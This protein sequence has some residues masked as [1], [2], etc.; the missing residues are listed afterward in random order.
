MRNRRCF[1]V[2]L[3]VGLLFTQLLTAQA[4]D[5]RLQNKAVVRGQVLDRSTGKGILNAY[6]E[7]LNYHPTISTSTD[8]NGYFELKNIPLGHQR[9]HVV[10]EGY[11]EALYTEL[12]IAGKESVV[13]ISMEEQ[14]QM[15]IVTVEGSS[16]GERTN[17]FRNTKQATI[18]PMNAVSARPLN[19]EEV[20][21]FV[22]GFNDP[23]RALTN[24]PGLYN[25]DDSQNY[26]I[27]R[28]NS[29]QG[30]QN[31]VEGVPIENPNH[32]P[33]L[34]HTGGI[35]PLVNSNA[36]ANSDFVNGAMGAHYGNVYSGVLDI[37]LRKGNNR[38]HEFMAQIGIFGAEAMAEGPISKGK[39]SYMVV[40]RIGIFSLL[41][42]AQID[43][44]TNAAPQYYDL[45]FKINRS[46]RRGG[47][48]S[49]FGIGGYA[50]VD[51]LDKDVD[52]SDIF[53]ERGNNA[54][55]RSYNFLAGVRNLHY[56]N[57]TTSLK[58]TISGVLQH[59][60]QHQDTLIDGM[61]PTLNYDGRL[62]YDRYGVQS[63]F[64]K[65]FSS[66]LL[67]RMGLQSFI[68]VYDTYRRYDIGK[69]YFVY[70]QDNLFMGSLFGQVQY[71]FSEKLTTTVGLH[72]YVLSLN[73]RNWSVEPRLAINWNLHQKHH[74]SLGYGWHSK[75]QS[76][77]FL[78]G[79]RLLP[80]GGYE[81]N[82][83]QLGPT[84]SHHMVLTY[85]WLIAKSWA[86]KFNTYVQYN[87]DLAVERTPSSYAAMNFEASAIQRPRTDLVNGG[88]QLNYGIEASIERFL[89]KGYYGL[90]SGTFQRSFYKG[91]DG[92]VRSTAYDVP[93]MGSLLAGKSFKI[94]KQKRNSIYADVRF[95]IRS[96]APTTP[97]DLEASRL[98]QNVVFREDQAFSE[99]LGMYKRLDLRLGMR[100]NHPTRRSSHHVYI[101]V[102]NIANFRNDL[103]VAYRVKEGRTV[104]AKQFGLF[105]N[106]L[107]QIRF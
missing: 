94:G 13:T 92:V 47:S 26:L 74:L 19:V 87:Y 57:E 53:T 56:F 104:R 59:Y 44:G 18:D 101:E 78:F 60:L 6:V 36:L 43:I 68:Y 24:Y 98:T 91:S 45:N 88:D 34:G 51:L 93:Y 66:K 15:T 72:A 107:Y 20:R 64:N 81:N 4:Q 42:A 70:G 33:V 54:Y 12:V 3:V 48:W 85:D 103:T 27:S 84:H 30:I 14:F 31:L 16:S 71:R 106:F 79:V 77:D 10:R 22:S 69:Q 8:E 25:L 67:F 41:Q 49:V 82:N 86:F 97:I 35:F 37:N 105:P 89:K 62:K 39:G 99:R 5:Q 29:P 50:Q 63:V 23:I 100:F 96:G 83:R 58:T 61:P 52:S 17:R 32:F 9:L 75:V 95:N 102:L 80:N 2:V 76:A 1:G 40:G 55:L 90:L 7:L 28:S 38:R 65:K 21:K 46:T 11:Y 73:N